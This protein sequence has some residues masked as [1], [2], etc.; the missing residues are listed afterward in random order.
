MP[1]I[2]S[3]LVWL[4]M[5]GLLMAGC[6]RPDPTMGNLEVQVWDHREAIGDFSELWLTIST[7]AIHQA[8]Q[9]RTQGW[10]ELEPSIQKLDLT[11]YIN[12]RKAVLVQVP[13]EIGAYN[14]IHLTINQV[15]GTLIDGQLVDVKA[16]LEPVALNFRIRDD[17]TTTLG[18]DLVVLDLSDHPT[19]G[20]TLQIREGVLIRTETSNRSGSSDK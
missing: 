13:V 8:G 19:Q 4:L 12:G 1:K 16:D 14:A 15:S 5:A 7:V 6:G 20:Y 10:V 3:G 11:Q 18:L 2:C 17:Q 9:P